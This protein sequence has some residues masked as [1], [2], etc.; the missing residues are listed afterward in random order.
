MEFDLEAELARDV[1]LEGDLAAVGID[2]MNFEI[3]A[4][5]RDHQT[6]EARTTADIG[7]HPRVTQMRDD[8][9]GIV[10]MALPDL[11][12]RGGRDEIDLRL[13]FFEKRLI[14]LKFLDSFSRNTSLRGEIVWGH[15]AFLT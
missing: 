1:D 14:S 11:R 3:G 8:L 9:P 12:Q 4:A 10:E 13:P 7:Q 2:R 6:R 5:G 15:A